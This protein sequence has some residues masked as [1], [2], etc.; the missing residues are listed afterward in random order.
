MVAFR[1]LGSLAAFLA[2]A[3]LFYCPA[4]SQT[5]PDLVII[6]A[7]AR[8]LVSAGSTAEAVSIRNGKIS[9]VGTTR[10]ISALAGPKTRIIDAK[11]RLVLPGFNDAHIHFMALGNMF[12]SID[13]RNARS[14]VDAVSKIAH[15][16]KFLPKNR[17]ILGGGWTSENWMP[18]GLP[19]KDLIDPVT[20]D[21]P[22]FIYHADTKSALA[23]TLA[24]KLAGIST[25]TDGVE[26]NLKGEPTG[27][28]R[29]AALAAVA[30]AI[31]TGHINDWSAIAET[32]TN[33]AASF[34]VTS[35]TDTQS[36]EHASVYRNLENAGKLKTRIYDCASLPY[37]PKKVNFTLAD[38]D[39]EKMVRT[40][41]VK[42]SAEGGQEDAELLLKDVIR[43]DKAGFQVLVHA[44][45][46]E[47]N[48]RVIDIFEKTARANG[49]KDRRFRIEHTHGTAETDIARIARS[50][51][52]ASS[53]PYLFRGSPV[54]SE[55]FR[56]FID[57]GSPVAF[58]ADAP[59]TDLDPML[60]IHAAVIPITG[61]GM[62]AYK[63]VRA[64]TVGSA[65]AE[66]Q[67]RAKGTIE[68]GKLA[69]LIILSDDIFEIEPAKIIDATVL[70]TIVNGR[71]VYEAQ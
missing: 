58:G 28:L 12:S 69:D 67:E 35:V 2:A 34:G 16:A 52:I 59:M 11:G 51:I 3:A 41:C 17:W 44:I 23:N 43:A 42:G 46:S 19:T 25:K 56:R 30:R 26:M 9:A 64:Y 4:F 13:L 1:K 55:A 71:V 48:S 57:L 33:Y 32:A 21:N 70:L 31:P 47:A 65:F 53:Q 22:V 49:K 50:G 37:L 6:N 38:R 66:F 29:G 10:R 60:G 5:A 18:A 54:E 15:Y 14:E 63:A 7:K 27:I 36:D 39:S 8:T 68:V 24:L 62:S 45:G 61:N 20:P 40:G